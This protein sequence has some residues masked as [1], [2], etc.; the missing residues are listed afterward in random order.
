MIVVVV[1]SLFNKCGDRIRNVICAKLYNIRN[2]YLEVKLWSVFSFMTRCRP[3]PLSPLLML[4]PLY[5]VAS[6][7]DGNT[8]NI[9]QKITVFS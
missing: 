1:L 2:I 8:R 7:F 4:F 5:Y 3:F 6:L 9:I